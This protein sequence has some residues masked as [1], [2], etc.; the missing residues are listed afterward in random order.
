MS[1]R[2]LIRQISDHIVNEIVESPADPVGQALY[3]CQPL[4][5]LGIQVPAFALQEAGQLVKRRLDAVVEPLVNVPVTDDPLTPSA[6]P[7]DPA[8][9]YPAETR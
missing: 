9:P 2:V 3:F 7:T 8:S 5:E 1:R 6:S 4:A